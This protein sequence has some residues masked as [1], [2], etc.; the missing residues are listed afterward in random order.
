MVQN[1][2]FISFFFRLFKNVTLISMGLIFLGGPGNVFAS[3]YRKIFFE[4]PP[5]MDDLFSLEM[6]HMSRQQEINLLEELADLKHGLRV[7]QRNLTRIC[8][9]PPTQTTEAERI[10]FEHEVE[11]AN[12]EVVEMEEKIKAGKLRTK[13]WR[14][15]EAGLSQEDLVNEWVRLLKQVWNH[16][17]KR[18]QAKLDRAQKRVEYVEGFLDRQYKLVE[19]G[20]IGKA[21]LED[22]RDEYKLAEAKLKQAKLDLEFALE[23]KGQFPDAP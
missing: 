17:F 15:S 5:T 18:A 2:R 10:R 13:M 9:L 11:Y 7:A 8:Q 20:A 6:A 3:S 16:N 1:I 19:R 12:Y 4:K 23:K 14:L 21:Q 22:I